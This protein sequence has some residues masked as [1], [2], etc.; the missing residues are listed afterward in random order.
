M[1]DGGCLCGRIRYHLDGSPLDAGFCHCVTCRR[2][3][4]APLVAWGTWRLPALSWLQGESREYASS[5]KGRRRFCPDCGTQLTF[6]H[7]DAPALVDVTLASLDDPDTVQPEYH[8]WVR[9]R[10]AWL[11]TA[12]A[13]PRHQDG[14]PDEELMAR[15]A[16]G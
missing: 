11:E 9:S 2:S 10:I 7:T 13:L 6:V 5:P 8:I 14:G 3:T 4:G 1:A 16:T 15:E 12:D